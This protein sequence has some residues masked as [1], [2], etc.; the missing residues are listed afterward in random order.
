M[1]RTLL[2]L[3]AIF[4]VAS[5][6]K[7]QTATSVANGNWYMPTTWDCLCIPT[8]AYTVNVN[9]DV[10]LDNDFALSGGTINIGSSG[11]LRENVTGRYLVMNT[12]SI[13]N[14]GKMKI[15]R[16]G[17]YGGNFTNYDSCVF[18]SVFYSGADA[19]NFGTISGVD[20]MFIQSYFYNDASGKID[21]L[22]VT[23]NDTL[24]N[25]GLIN[26]TDLLNMDVFYNNNE[27]NFNNF[28]S[29][30]FTVNDNVITFY[31]FT[32]NG[33]F[34]NYGNMHGNSD[35][36]NI[37]Y[38]Y[39][40][41]TGS[42]ILGNDFSNTDSINHLAYFEN[43]GGIYVARNFFNGD[44]IFGENGHICVGQSSAN[45]GALLGTFDFCDLTGGGTPDF[46]NGPI[47][48]GI[49]YCLNS[50][51]ES[52]SN[53][54]VS[55]QQLSVYPNPSADK[56]FFE[57]SEIPSNAVITITDVLGNIIFT[58]AVSGQQNLIFKKGDTPAGLYI[59]KVVCDGQTV[60]GKILLQ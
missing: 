40:D 59:Y 29:N 15:S 6:G 21:A 19:Q 37:G 5:I 16:V 23:V 24:E 46:N 27:A 55:T 35:A 45:N 30:N 20:S 18:N 11:V 47:S 10:V 60:A 1:K 26:V 50:C 8:A 22:R 17:F 42:L 51:A 44:T 41:T 57:F 31:D 4:F 53:Q 58:Q 39:N 9:H 2:F 49:T 34:E 14:N 48:N 7:S 28:F 38:F 3:A 54:A 56:V 33:N 43:E 12:G 32:N 13:T 36:T 25:D 52:V